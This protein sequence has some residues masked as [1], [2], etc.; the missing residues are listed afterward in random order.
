[1]RGVE[2]V[3][4]GRPRRD[5][6]VDVGERVGQVAAVLSRSRDHRRCAGRH[7][8]DVVQA[9]P[10]CPSAPGL[11]AASPSHDLAVEGVLDVAAAVVGRLAVAACAALVSLSVNSA[12]RIASARRAGAR[13]ACS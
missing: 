2:L 6:R 13:P 1:M 3:G 5:D 8:A 4:L 12:L 7:A 10:W 11:H 9:R